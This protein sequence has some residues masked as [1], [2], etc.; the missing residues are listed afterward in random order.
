[1]H[2]LLSE[3]LRR[4]QR[5]DLRHRLGE[6]LIRA[7]CWAAVILALLPR[8]G[9]LA[10]CALVLLGEGAWLWH[11]WRTPLQVAEAV[12]AGA[13]THGLLYTALAAEQER[14]WGSEAL[15]ELV[16]ERARAAAPSLTEHAIRR[17]R[18]PRAVLLTGLLAFVVL[19]LP[20]RTETGQ[21]L[22]RLETQ[23]ASPPDDTPAAA[24][25]EPA[26]LDLAEKS[27]GVGAL[28]DGDAQAWAERGEGEGAAGEIQGILI[29]V[30]EHGEVDGF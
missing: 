21:A 15:L 22:T 3:Q 12:D 4:W 19:L 1:M 27:D 7:A 8:S 26:P 5:L 13:S 23:L 18:L 2:P 9:W 20:A 11:R 16:Q 28:A 14:A 29:Y 10:A 25:S 24:S 30:V 17:L 6:A